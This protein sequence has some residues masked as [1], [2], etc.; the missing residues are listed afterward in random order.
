MQVSNNSKTPVEN[1]RKKNLV[2]K[3]SLNTNNFTNYFNKSYEFPVL[4]ELS[5]ASRIINIKL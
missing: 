1:N 4:D 5:K 3:L 2:G